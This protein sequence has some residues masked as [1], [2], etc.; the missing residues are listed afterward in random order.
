MDFVVIEIDF[1]KILKD[2]INN[3]GVILN[4]KSF[5]FNYL[6]K[7]IEEIVKLIINNY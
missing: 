3:F 5:I 7:S 2:K 1:E 4:N 6:N